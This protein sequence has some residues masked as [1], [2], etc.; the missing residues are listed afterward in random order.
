MRDVLRNVL[1]PYA[2]GF[3]L[4]ALL[5][6]GLLL[7]NVGGLWTLIGKSDHYAYL[8]LLFFLFANVFG[9]LSAATYLQIWMAEQ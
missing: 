4:G 9:G 2:I 1:V 5:C 8:F 6:L 3:G 7:L